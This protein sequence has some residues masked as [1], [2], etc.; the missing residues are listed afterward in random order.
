MG[1]RL[2]TV[3]AGLLLFTE[4]QEFG[5]WLDGT[6]ERCRDLIALAIVGKHT[7]RSIQALYQD[8]TPGDGAY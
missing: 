8:H 3:I 4:T 6:K 5:I 1:L 7:T 2:L